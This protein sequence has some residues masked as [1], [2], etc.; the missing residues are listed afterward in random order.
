[1][2]K[3]YWGEPD[4]IEP[5]PEWMLAETHRNPLK[6]KIKQQTVEDAARNCLKK[7]PIN[8]SNY[9]PEIK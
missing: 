9:I 2:N 4:D 8:V 1:M 6:Q 3:N 5:L 7:P